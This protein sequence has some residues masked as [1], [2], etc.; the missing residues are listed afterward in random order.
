[1]ERAKRKG[2]Q[3]KEKK[4]E[5]RDKCHKKCLQKNQATVPEPGPTVKKERE[6]ISK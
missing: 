4:T 1:M 2:M 3:G 6:I 5:I